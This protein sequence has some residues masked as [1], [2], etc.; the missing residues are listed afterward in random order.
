LV[1]GFAGDELDGGA[2]GGR[3]AALMTKSNKG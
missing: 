3:T 1:H 2:A